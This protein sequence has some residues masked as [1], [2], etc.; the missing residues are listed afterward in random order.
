MRVI[1]YHRIEYTTYRFTITSCL[2]K[3]EYIKPEIITHYWNQSLD[4]APKK[5]FAAVAADWF[6]V[7]FWLL[8]VDEAATGLVLVRFDLLGCEQTQELNRM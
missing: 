5:D 7:G 2:D 6:A 4:I 8:A 3:Y 1:Y